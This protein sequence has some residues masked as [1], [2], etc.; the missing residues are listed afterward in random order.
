MKDNTERE[1]KVLLTKEQYE[2]LLHSYDFDKTITQ[3]NTY[4]DT[5]D[6]QLK[7]L[8]GAL[9]IRNI[10]EQNILTLKLPQDAIT[11]QEYEIPVHTSDIHELSPE[12]KK[13]ITDHVDLK[14]DVSPIARFTTIRNL[15]YLPN[16]ELCLDENHFGNVTDYELE[17]E[18]TTDHDGIQVLNDI[19]KPLGLH[20]E[21]NGPSKLARAISYKL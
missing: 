19:L 15:K 1:L 9:R 18:Y 8:G 6:S 16:A 21:K 3:T 12:E 14:K 2:K 13:T 11:K 10:G 20:F 5:E 4:Y 17:Y 7:N